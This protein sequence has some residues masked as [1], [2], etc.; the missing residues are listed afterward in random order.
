MVGDKAICIGISEFNGSIYN[1]DGIDFQAALQYWKENGTLRNFP[2]CAF[3]EDNL[4]II[5]KPCDI[6]APCARENIFTSENADMFQCKL[7]AEG[8]NGPV[9]YKA[10]KI[11]DNKGIVCLPDILCNSGGVTVSFFE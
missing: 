5:T 1:E 2:G 10:D 4:S 8:A 3:T 11:L 9:T 6:F 7:V